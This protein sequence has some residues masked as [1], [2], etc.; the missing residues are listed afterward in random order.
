MFDDVVSRRIRVGSRK[1]Y[2]LPLSIVVHALLVTVVVI[3]PLLATDVLPIPFQDLQ[4]RLVEVKTPSVPSA[5]P[6]SQTT[7]RPAGAQPPVNAAPV[8]TPDRI[9]PES[10]LVVDDTPLSI[11]IGVPGG[12]PPGGGD[13]GTTEAPPPPSPPPPAPQSTPMRVGGWI[14]AP[15]RVNYVRPVYP[16]IAQQAR[17]Q[18]VVILEVTIGTDGRVTNAT[19][20]RSIPLLDRAALDSVTQWI[21]RPTLL[22]GVPV[23]ILMTVTVN[24]QLQ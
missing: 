14:V 20:L 2:T 8:Q 22:N 21:F 7:R 16:A 1:W 4:F 23:P 3:V 6:A 9:T 17:V 15:Q 18:G 11:G 12:G 19:I 10:G 13:V 24:F 5:P